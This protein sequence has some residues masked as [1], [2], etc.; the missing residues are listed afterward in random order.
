MK[1]KRLFLAMLPVL[2]VAASVFGQ[3]PKREVVFTMNANEVIYEGE[4]ASFLKFSQKRF[5]CLVH[6]T[7]TDLCTLVFNGKR[8]KTAPENEWVPDFNEWY[9]YYVNPDEDKGYIFK[10]KE[11]DKWYVNCRGVVAG[12][13]DNAFYFTG[14]YDYGDVFTTAKDY[15]YLYKL[16][17]LWYA[18]KNRKKE[19]VHFI[20]GIYKDWKCYVNVN[21]TN[22][23][24]PYGIAY[25]WRLTQSRKY[26]F[27]YTDDDG[28][29]YMNVNG[30]T[31]GGPY[32][33]DSYDI[34]LVL[35]ESGKYAYTYGNSHDKFGDGYYGY[36]FFVNVNGSI[37]GEPYTRSIYSLALSESGIYA[38]DYY[39]DNGWYVTVNGS[40]VG[41][42]Y[43]EHVF[44]LTLTDNG[45]YAYAYNNNGKWYVNINGATVGGPYIDAERLTLA[46]NGE[47]SYYYHE[48]RKYYR[49]TNGVVTEE[50]DNQLLDYRYSYNNL[51]LT[52]KDGK[53]SFSSS[54]EHK[55]VVIDGRSYGRSSA[56]EAW[57]DASK[58]AFLWSTVEDRELVVYEYALR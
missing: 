58:N 57:Y 47:Y 10:Y 4:L 7:V 9:L 32:L 52:S 30:F 6:D 24:G 44:C 45:K 18:V 11:N 8:I 1:A 20:E 31:V 16:D 5:G 15:D 56:V 38:Y 29:W 33:C 17:G 25:Y 13:F 22:V 53:H 54:Y 2:V 55:Y 19:K 21:G 51:N 27:F 50:R 12:G 48:N 39:D 3:A 40:I 37:V 34:K 36:A 28:K 42:P 35:T 23:G 43:K 41:G 14:Y 46:E 49:N 26:A